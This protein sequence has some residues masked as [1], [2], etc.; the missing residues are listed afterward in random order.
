[1]STNAKK[2]RNYGKKAVDIAKKKCQHNVNNVNNVN[3]KMLTLSQ[4]C[5]QIF[6]ECQ[7][8]FS[9]CQQSMST[10]SR[11]LNETRCAPYSLKRV[12]LVARSQSGNCARSS[13]T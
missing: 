8:I 4:Q 13:L 12:F 2:R 10:L 9:E 6:G 3:K 7:Q 1:M 5:Q 11:R